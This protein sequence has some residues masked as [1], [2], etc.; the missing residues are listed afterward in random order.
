ML[1]SLLATST[2]FD[3]SLSIAKAYVLQAAED[4]NGALKIWNDTLS[5]QVSSPKVRL[6]VEAERAWC[7]FE[8]GELE[9][10]TE[11]LNE[12]AQAFE[13]RKDERDEEMKIKMKARSKAGIELE[14][15]V[16]EGETTVESE[17]RARGWWRLGKCYWARTG[18]LI[19]Y[20]E[21]RTDTSNRYRAR[22]PFESLR[23]LRG[24][25]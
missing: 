5:S 7:L 17:E 3:I 6:E 11:S 13:K 4:W 14:E 12:V 10:A 23:F 20:C 25:N 9:M 16:Q 2:T 8:A 15:G 1:E 18:S 22:I 24:F 19:Q 21:T